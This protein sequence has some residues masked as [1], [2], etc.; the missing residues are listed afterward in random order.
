MEFFNNPEFADKFT[1]EQLDK[2]KYDF[3]EIEYVEDNHEEG[4]KNI[5]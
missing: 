1:F 4:V 2:I 3:D 5:N